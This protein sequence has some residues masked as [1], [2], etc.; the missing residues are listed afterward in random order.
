M[1]TTLKIGLEKKSFAVLDT[2]N[3]PTLARDKEKREES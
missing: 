1:T 2:Y 3:D